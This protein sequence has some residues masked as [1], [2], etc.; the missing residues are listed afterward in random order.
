VD[1][2]VWLLWMEGRIHGEYEA[3]E[4]PIGY[5]P[6]YEDLRSLFQSVFEREYTA[7]EYEE[8]FSIRIDKFLEK[9]DRMEKIYAEEQEV[10]EAFSAYLQSLKKRLE[11]SRSTHGSGV[12][13]PTAFAQ[14]A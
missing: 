4:T 14:T 13:S 5:I 1:K 7:E 6:L 11:D 2:K 10:P 9:I 3:V 8:Q 12:V